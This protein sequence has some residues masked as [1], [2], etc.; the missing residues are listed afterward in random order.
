[1]MK[2]ISYI[3]SAFRERFNYEFFVRCSPCSH[4]RIGV[5]DEPDAF[6]NVLGLTA[7]AM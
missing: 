6:F 4:L 2:S 1:M 3:P 7:L 5:N